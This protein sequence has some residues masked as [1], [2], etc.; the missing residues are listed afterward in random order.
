EAGAP[1]H[2]HGMHVPVLLQRGVPARRDLEVAHLEGGR[3]ALPAEERVADHVLPAQAA[4]RR[5]GVLILVDPLGHAFPAEPV[6]L[7]AAD[8]RHPRHSPFMV[9]TTLSTSGS[10]TMR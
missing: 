8:G 6:R 9:T 5:R 3:L 10:L 7:E 4:L 1:H 2:G